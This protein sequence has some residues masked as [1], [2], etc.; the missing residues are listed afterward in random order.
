MQTYAIKINKS[1]QNHAMCTGSS[2]NPVNGKIFQ[3]YMDENIISI[4]N[5]SRNT[6][7]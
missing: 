3:L 5:F 6:F 1:T 4:L 2:Q 7:S